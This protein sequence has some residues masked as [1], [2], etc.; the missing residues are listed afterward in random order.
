MASTSTLSCNAF[1]APYV[2]QHPNGSQKEICRACCEH[3]IQQLNAL[4]DSDMVVSK[5]VKAIEERKRTREVAH[6]RISASMAA[7]MTK[8]VLT[9]L[10]GRFF[11]RSTVQ[12]KFWPLGSKK[13]RLHHFA[14]C[15]RVDETVRERA[16]REKAI[17]ED[18]WFAHAIR[19]QEQEKKRKRESKIGGKARKS[20]RLGEKGKRRSSYDCSDEEID[21]LASDDGGLDKGASED[22]FLA[23]L[24]DPPPPPSSTP[25]PRRK[26]TNK[27]KERAGDGV[28][29]H[30]E[31]G[32]GRKKKSK[33]KSLEK[34]YGIT[35]CSDSGTDEE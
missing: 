2:E 32:D 17:Q 35:P 6:S 31:L 18:P 28:E 20:R 26:V 33:G 24:N 7:G 30:D 4:N 10:Y 3:Y 22:E 12:K 13:D 27:G 21:E 34:D 25:R 23:L 11:T 8:I 1:F 14:F 9:Y 29:N 19:E 16:K 15:P 5:K